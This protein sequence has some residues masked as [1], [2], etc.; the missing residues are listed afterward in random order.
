MGMPTGARQIVEQ[1]A[2]AE[3]NVAHASELRCM[4]ELARRRRD[5]AAECARLLARVRH[6]AGA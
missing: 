3:A 4:D 2:Q 5:L 1:L 6:A